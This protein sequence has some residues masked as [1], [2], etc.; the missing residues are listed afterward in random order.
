M[1][2]SETTTSPIH[3]YIDGQPYRHPSPR[4]IDRDRVIDHLAT[5]I[6][7]VDLDLLDPSPSSFVR[8][9]HRELKIRGYTRSTIRNYLSAIK[10][11]LRWFGGRPGDMDREYVRDYLEYLVDGEHSMSDVAVQL[12]AIRT[13][14]D[15]FCFRDITLGLATPRKPKQRVV[16]LSR[17]EIRRLLE[18]APSMRDTLLIGLMY[19]TGMRVSEVVKVRWQDIDFDRNQIFIRQGKGRAD[20]HV[21]L[22]QCYR[23]LLG[24]LG[25]DRQGDE[26]LF[27]SESLS[28]RR[29]GRHL[30]P[31][32]VQRV[33]K[34]ACEVAGIKKKATPHSLRHAFATHSFE[35]GCDIRRIQTVLGH[36]RLETTTI[37]VK[38]A[39]GRTEMP[40]PLDRLPTS[41][42][43]DMVDRD[44]QQKIIGDPKTVHPVGSLRIHTRPA[45]DER[46]ADIQV[47]LEINNPSGRQFLTGIRCRVARPGFL[48]IELPPLESWQPILKKLPAQQAARIRDPVFYE[49]LQYHLTQKVLSD[50][51]D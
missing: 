11:L 1:S 31:R 49:T 44:A 24:E 25:N 10:S 48:T 30:S 15:K 27:P 36:V 50:S 3:R 33:M 47:T 41:A 29:S 26:F 40:S 5:S 35:D 45:P 7:V 12:T 13:I 23:K 6:A 2:F 9:I 39:K 21:R 51:P 17:D 34:N 28:D 32:T 19:A 38:V 46:S 37:Y 20:R 4:F 18:A 8:S 42:N 43:Q 16:V 22:P 14:F